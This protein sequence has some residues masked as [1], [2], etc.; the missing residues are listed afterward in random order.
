VKTLLPLEEKWRSS[1]IWSLLM[2]AAAA[3]VDGTERRSRPFLSYG[4]IQF[5]PTSQHTMHLRTVQQALLP[6]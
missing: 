5:A 6:T 4:L 2:D 3:A 1:S